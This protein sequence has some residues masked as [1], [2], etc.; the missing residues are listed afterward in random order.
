MKM[1]SKFLQKVLMLSRKNAFAKQHIFAV[2]LLFGFVVSAQTPNSQARGKVIDAATGLPVAAAQINI[3]DKNISAVTDSVGS[4]VVDVV[5]PSDV[6]SVTAYGYAKRELS[7]RGNADIVIKLYAWTFSSYFKNVKT[8]TSVVNQANTTASVKT[9]PAIERPTTYTADDIIRTELAGDVRGISRSGTAAVGSS[10]F[11]RGINSLNANSQPLFVVDGV[12]WNN[13]QEYSS[14]QGG[15]F[16]N[17]LDNIDA[18]DIESISVIKDGTTIY[19]SKGANGVVLI[20]TKRSQSMVTKI[21][22]NMTAGLIEQPGLLPMM[23]AEDYR[24]YASD[25]LYSAG[26]E[27]NDVSAYPFLS[28][29]PSLASYNTY[30]SQTD[31]SKEVYQQGVA[32]NYLINAQGGDD[33]AMYYFSLG[34]SNNDG[35]VKTTDLN[36]LNARFNADMNLFDKLKMGLNIGFTR[37]ERKMIDDG[38]NDYSSPGYLAA[39]KAPFLSPYSFTNE[40]SVTANYAPFDIFGV[41][42]PEALIYGSINYFKKY[43]FNISFI[44][45]YEISPNLTLSSQ[46]DYS[47]YKTVEGH[48]VPMNYSMP[49]YIQDKGYSYN[50]ISSQVIRNSSIFNETKL[51]YRKTYD[52]VHSLTALVGF[53]YINNYYESDFVREHNSGSNNNTTITGSYDF[54]EVDGINNRTKSISN[55]LSADYAYDNRYFITAAM[56]M[57]ASSKF[58]TQTEGGIQLFGAS[59]G[60][61][62]SLQSAWLM[63]SEEFMKSAGAI[64]FLKLRAGYGITGNDGIPDY[65]TSTYFNTVRLIDKANG[66]LIGN[67]AN[68]HVQ[69]ETNAKVNFGFDLGLFDDIVN[70]NLDLFQSSISDMLVLRELPYY[71]GLSY[72]WDN[73]GS[74]R[75]RGFE[76]SA[77]IKLV[78]TQFFQWEAGFTAGHYKNEVTSLIEGDY[79]M[80]VFAG[81]VLTAVGE[82]FGSFYGYKTQGVFSTQEQADAAGLTQYMSNGTYVQFNAGDMIFEDVNGDKKIN[83]LDKQVIGNANPELY[84]NFNTKM[85][86]NRFTLSALFTYSYGNDLYNYYRQTLESG[87]GFY[88]Q[89]NALTIRWTADGQNTSIPKATYGDPMGNARFSDRWIED[90]SYLKFKNIS[91]SYE[92]PLISDYIEGLNLWISAENLNTWTNYLGLDPEV[93]VSNSQYYQGVDA[94]LLPLTRAYYVGLKLNL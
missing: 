2:F 13:F 60:L 63:S 66:L 72:F 41:G 6:L 11:I 36:R 34:F 61:F 82:S 78:N 45:T 35:V 89:T 30:H 86:F 69:W 83:S 9:I 8:T 39:I 67:L 44:P 52:K 75:N 55:Y 43:R 17:P 47:L 56:A 80:N 14:I 64:S 7:L 65:Q 94:G 84:G 62:P 58:G 57:D 29:D 23:D 53:R 48:F 74:M 92:L 38:V 76:L 24:L 50:Q 22:A 33:K 16:S 87:A 15:Y 93:S 37:N 51:K 25:M 40:G 91:L 3:L 88:N 18:Q 26:F 10:L 1:K 81:Q 59:W 68:E 73:G 42:N 20:S 70:V 27:G 79:T 85:S 77:N 5:S 90:G 19:G 31:W 71:S 21:S 32:Q 12:V 4:F 54:L 28:A 46:F 49:Q